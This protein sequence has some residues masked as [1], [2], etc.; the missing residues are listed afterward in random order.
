MNIPQVPL[1]DL[2]DKS[3]NDIA[4]SWRNF[5]NQLVSELQTYVSN[6]GFVN[7]TQSA[8]DISIIEGNQLADGSYTCGFG[9]CLYNSTANTIQFSID[10]GSGAPEFKTVTLT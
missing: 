1:D 10:D 3:T 7:P 8:S 9:R 4:S 2:I 5:F 6:E